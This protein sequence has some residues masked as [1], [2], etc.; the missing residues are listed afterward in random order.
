MKTIKKI[1]FTGLTASLAVGA[2]TIFAESAPSGSYTQS[3]QQ[4]TLED[5]TLSAVCKTRAGQLCG[6]SQ[7]PRFFPDPLITGLV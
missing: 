1:L 2:T 3:C 4:I 6:Q 5:T 7:P